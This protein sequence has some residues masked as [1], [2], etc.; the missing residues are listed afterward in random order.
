MK[1][2]ST[3]VLIFAAMLL[4]AACNP[5]T[6]EYAADRLEQAAES[7]IDATEEKLESAIDPA[8][9]A[10]AD[11]ISQEDAEKIALE[12][13]GLLADDVR[14]LRTEHEIDDGVPLYEVLFYHENLEYDYEI[15]AET[16]EIL[17]Y[18]RDT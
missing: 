5:Q 4:F 17:S 14:Q 2:N 16:G 1:L 15:H 7:S 6:V 10:S 12:H 9:D 13:A 18:D 11:A 8:A 3:V